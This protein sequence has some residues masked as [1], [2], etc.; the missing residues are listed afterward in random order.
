M[1]PQLQLAPPSLVVPYK[2]PFCQNQVADGTIPSF[3]GGLTFDQ[4]G[5][6]YAHVL[7]RRL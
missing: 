3:H 5:N 4:A 6:L 1:V 2:A 7:R